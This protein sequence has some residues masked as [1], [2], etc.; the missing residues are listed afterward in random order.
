MDPYRSNH[1]DNSV[2]LMF[3]IFRLSS[4]ILCA[5]QLKT[6]ARKFYSFE[7]VISTPKSVLTQSIKASLTLKVSPF[8]FKSAG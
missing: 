5:G 7:A 1:Q 4:E 8:P 3:G 2:F 6:P